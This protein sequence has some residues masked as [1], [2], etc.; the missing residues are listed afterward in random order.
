[1][2]SSVCVYQIL[3]TA[4]QSDVCIKRNASMY[5]WI[6]LTEFAVNYENNNNPFAT[7]CA[8]QAYCIGW[9]VRSCFLYKEKSK[10]KLMKY[11]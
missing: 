4:E 2:N 7:E 8:Y 5:L 6:Y 9:C 10:G 3:Y 11:I 1:M